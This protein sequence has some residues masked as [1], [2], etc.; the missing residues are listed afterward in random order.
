MNCPY[1]GEA[2]KVME[3]GTGQDE[4]IRRRKC[5]SCGKLFHTVE[6]D[7]DYKEGSKLLREYK[8]TSNLFKIRHL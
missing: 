8:E 2:T 4:I 1:C 7:I 3:T 6:R 5:L